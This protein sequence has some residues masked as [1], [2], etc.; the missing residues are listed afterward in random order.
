MN[1]G[2]NGSNNIGSRT[3]WTETSVELGHPVGE[4]YDARNDVYNPQAERAYY[5]MDCVY[6]S[7]IEDIKAE[8][9]IL[10]NYLVFGGGSD[11]ADFDENLAEV[12]AMCA[13]EAGIVSS[14]E[15]KHKS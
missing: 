4:L 1:H 10:D 8:E 7:A 2:C 13:G 6:M 3:N 15:E 14:Y 5:S 12:K 9:E 11:Q